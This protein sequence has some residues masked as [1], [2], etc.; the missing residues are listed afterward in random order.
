[1]SNSKYIDSLTK[2][3]Y[4]KL[5]QKLFNQQKGDIIR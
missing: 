3:E 2:E 5:T 4:D 1:M